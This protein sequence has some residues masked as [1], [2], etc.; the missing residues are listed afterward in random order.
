[1]IHGRGG[2][3]RGGACVIFFPPNACHSR[4]V[5]PGGQ[6]AHSPSLVHGGS[7]CTPSGRQAVCAGVHTGLIW[8]L[9]HH[10]KQ[11]NLCPGS[12]PSARRCIFLHVHNGGSWQEMCCAGGWF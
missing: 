6:W 2:A 3:A 1:M 10:Q 7:A 11:E 5:P 9:L 4:L 12:L 8:L